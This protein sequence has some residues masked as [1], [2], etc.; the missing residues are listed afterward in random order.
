MAAYTAIDDAGSFFNPVL[1]SATGSSQAVTGVGFAPDF[2]WIKLRTSG[3]VHCLTDSIRGV[4]KYIQSN[5]NVAEVTNAET[6]KSF[7]SDGFTIGTD[8]IVSKTGNTAVSW[9]W[10]A[11]TTTGI[12]G[13]PSITPNSYSFNATSGFSIIQYSGDSNAGATLPHGL[14]VAPNMIMLKPVDAVDNWEVYTSA[15]GATKHL[16]L[17]T[18]VVAGTA[19]NRWNDTAPTSTLFSL[20]DGGGVNATGVEFLTYCFANVQ[21]YS[22][23]GSYVGNGNADG[24]F[25]YTGFRPSFFMLKNTTATYEWFI[26]DSKRAGYNMANYYIHANDAGTEG[27][28]NTYFEL[29][30][31]SNGVKMTNSHAQ[32]NGSGVTYIYMAFAENP[33]VNSEG[34]P[35]NA[36]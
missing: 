15:L 16:V 6:L 29:N 31:L 35:V 21:G 7:D 19:T 23:F 22:K 18:T 24:T 34:V 33:F 8:D 1:Y 20:G 32:L 25:V 30:F 28:D 36:R 2:T 10:K 17:N 26:M 27:T 11:G 13:S 5:S 12:A 14:G 3:Q 9:N 4:T